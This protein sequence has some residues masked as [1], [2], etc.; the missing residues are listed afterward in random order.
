MP[1]YTHEDRIV[2]VAWE[3][4]SVTLKARKSYNYMDAEK[5]IAADGDSIPR[6]H[7][8]LFL[9]F[10]FSIRSFR[11]LYDTSYT[12]RLVSAS[13]PTHLPLPS[14]SVFCLHFHPSVSRVPR[15]LSEKQ[16]FVIFLTSFLYSVSPH[17]IMNPFLVSGL[18]LYSI[19]HEYTY[20]S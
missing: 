3:L 18:C 13:I 17:L 2:K 10:V 7:A 15:I 14:V 19:A 20:K 5:A 16:C 8:L 6:S 12:L 11:F 4:W 1:P 9:L